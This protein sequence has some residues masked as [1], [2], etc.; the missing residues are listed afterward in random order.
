MIATGSRLHLESHKELSL[1]KE[2]LIAIVAIAVSVQANAT[3]IK[4]LLKSLMLEVAR[5]AIEIKLSRLLV[6][7]HLRH[8]WK[9]KKSAPRPI[10]R[11]NFLPYL[12]TRS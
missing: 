6:R 1:L 5:Q 2:L 12:P 9:E 3:T 10:L 8:N 11:S 4:L 7:S